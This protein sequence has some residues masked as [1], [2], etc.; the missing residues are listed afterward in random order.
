[1]VDAFT[2]LAEPHRRA[3]LNHLRGGE[4]SVGELVDHSGLSQPSVSKHLRV[5]REAGLV[6]VRPD[7]Q[8]RLYELEVEPL[9]EV[10]AWLTPYRRLWSA[11]LGRL[12]GHLATTR[13]NAKGTAPAGEGS[14]Q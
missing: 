3:I 9:R 1:M 2:V 4:A 14:G 10:D 11:A 6:R 7:R 5:L 8:R 13:D 12:E